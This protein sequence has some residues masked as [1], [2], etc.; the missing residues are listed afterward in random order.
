MNPG[1]VNDASTLFNNISIE[2]IKVCIACKSILFD[3]MT[4]HGMTL[5]FDEIYGKEIGKNRKSKLVMQQ[6]GLNI[7]VFVTNL[8]IKENMLRNLLITT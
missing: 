8:T 3:K 5:R 2:C 7:N 6:T 1:S 4:N